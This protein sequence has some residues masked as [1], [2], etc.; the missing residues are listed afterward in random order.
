MEEACPRAYAHG[1]LMPPCGLSGVRMTSL[2]CEGV[3]VTVGE[4]AQVVLERFAARF[5]YADWTEDPGI[6]DRP[7][8]EVAP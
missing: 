8:A 4:V 5:G 2:A 6:D 1:W 3:R 7:S